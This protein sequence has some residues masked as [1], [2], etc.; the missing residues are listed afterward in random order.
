MFSK[1]VLKLEQ[2]ISALEHATFDF[3]PE[4]YAK[5]LEAVGKRN[6]MKAAITKLHEALK[7]D[8]EL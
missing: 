6:G 8:D 7:E 4:N 1:L 5:F 3:P 2:E